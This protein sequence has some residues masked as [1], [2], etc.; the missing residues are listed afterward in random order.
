MLDFPPCAFS[1]RFCAHS[2]FV[3]QE[4]IAIFSEFVFKIMPHSQKCGEKA[5]VVDV[6]HDCCTVDSNVRLNLCDIS[7]P[8]H[9]DVSP[10]ATCWTVRTLRRCGR[11]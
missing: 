10:S 3:A 1:H 6:A 4:I 5:K 7:F 9:Q 11:K 2:I 8:E